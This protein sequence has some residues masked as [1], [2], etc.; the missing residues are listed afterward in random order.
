VLI[1]LSQPFSGESAGPD[2]PRIR[3]V[4]H[5]QGA[6]LLGL[7]A[8]VAD[9]ETIWQ[10]ARGLIRGLARGERIGPRDFPD[11]Q[12]LALE[13]VR[14]DTHAGT[15]MDAPYHFGPTVNGE[16]A[17]T[18]DQVPL[19][20]CFGDGVVLDLRHKGPGESIS[21]DDLR[22]ALGRIGY[23]L[24]PL[25][26]VLVM[27]GAAS[28]AGEP[29]YLRRQPGM[30]AEGTAYL[31]DEGI[32]VI[33]VDAYCFDRPW[34][35]MHREYLRTREPEAL[36]PAHLVGRRR[37]YCHL[38]NLANLERIPVAHGFTVACFPIAVKGGGAG[39][40]RAVAIVPEDG[41]ASAAEA[42]GGRKG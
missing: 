6:V 21:S 41:E 5:R 13:A 34:A 11:G 9:G 15:H 2:P 8:L 17:R 3:Y 38:E 30:T 10:R 31:L 1:D 23:S 18:I 20:W 27:T 39:W 40:V 42:H 33:G 16:A 7:G 35:V 26:I 12:G 28:H 32:K 22:Q 14:C 4:P 25:D 24:K 37:E 29:G 36:W 19:E